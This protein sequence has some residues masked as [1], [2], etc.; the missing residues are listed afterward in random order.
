MYAIV[1][2]PWLLACSAI[3]DAIIASVC[4]VLKTQWRLASTGS[5]IFDDDA[6]EIIGVWPSA[7]T[8]IMASEFGVIDEPMIASTW[9]SEISFFVVWTACG[10][11]G[12]IEN[13]VVHRAAAHFLR[14]QR[15]RIA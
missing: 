2:T 6:S 4:G 11:G 9:S 5:M 15:H 14:Q 3:A 1:F 10:V 12:I 13:D 7:T 8:S